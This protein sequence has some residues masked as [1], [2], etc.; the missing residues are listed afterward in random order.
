VQ[1]FASGAIVPFRVEKGSVS[2]LELLSPVASNAQPNAPDAH[3]VFFDAAC[4]RGESVNLP[5]TTNDVEILS[6]GGIATRDGLVV[7][8]ATRDGGFTLV[9]PAAPMT[10]RVHHINVAE[11]YARVFDPI[12]V[13][14]AEIEDAFWNPLTPFGAFFA[15]PEGATFQTTLTFVCP[16]TAVTTLI[17]VADG[18]PPPPDVAS[19]IGGVV[20]DD[21][22]TPLRDI[23][24]TCRC[25][26]V[27]SVRELSTVY[28]DLATA[29]NGT[30]TKLLGTPLFS[31]FVAWR[32]IRVLDGALPG[33]NLDDWSRV[34][35]LAPGPLRIQPVGE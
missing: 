11:D 3:L 16:T 31:T 21:E 6:L 12:T 4:T 18:W 8:V 25:L 27:R 30:L 34:T 20:Y 29:P 13:R 14:H 17:S 32:A 2:F 7:V 28:T 23:S 19:T 9:P 26:T 33:G 35:S 1:L 15:P 24:T 10:A 22:E 5:V